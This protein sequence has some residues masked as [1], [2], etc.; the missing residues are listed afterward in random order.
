MVLNT[1]RQDAALLKPLPA[2]SDAETP[3]WFWLCR[4]AKERIGCQ[5]GVCKGGSVSRFASG[6]DLCQLRA[7]VLWCGQLPLQATLCSSTASEVPTHIA[8]TNKRV[9]VSALLLY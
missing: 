3:M 8:D 2:P 9:S 5:P 6:G 1:G 7:G 4:L